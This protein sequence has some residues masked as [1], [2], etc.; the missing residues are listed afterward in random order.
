MKQVCI[1]L[2]LFCQVAKAQPIG[3]APKNNVQL[4]YD[5]IFKAEAFIIRHQL[6]SC[7]Y[8]F[9]QAFR[10]LPHPFARHVY[11]AA[12]ANAQLKNYP[13][14]YQHLVYLYQ[15]GASHKKLKA[16]SSFA[17]F[18][19]SPQGKKISA[20]YKKIKPVYNA[21]YRAAILKM[22]EDDQVFRQKP[23]AYK[24][25]ND[26]IQAID[27]R[28]VAQLLALMDKYGFPTE[29]AIGVNADALSMPLY[30]ILILHQS[31][32]PLQQFDFSNILV[33][34]IMAG[35]LENKAGSFLLNR[36]SGEGGFEVMKLQLVALID[37]TIQWND[38]DNTKLIK[39]TDWGYFPLSEKELNKAN[40]RRRQLYLDDWEANIR[41]VLF[42]L[43]Q[44]RFLI[45]SSGGAQSIIYTDAAGF[46]SDKAKMRFLE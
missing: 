34:A 31:N 9:A 41:T 35:Q 42:G 24:L 39:E 45:F 7:A 3:Q 11:N 43:K 32:G 18:F 22:A 46:E 12:V 23:N 16:D 25:Y 4:Y 1:A 44:K 28:N 20:G 19:A 36:S 40:M 17:S 38:G 10:Q 37:T 33:K 2:L 26:T 6:D 29:Q 13:L 8:Y 15:L 30:E 27:K 5:H 21:R 14:V